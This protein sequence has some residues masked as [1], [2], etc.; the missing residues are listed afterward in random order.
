MAAVYADYANS[1][2]ALANQARKELV[3]TGNLKY[4]KTA[5]DTYRAEVASL[6][7][8]LKAAELNTVRERAA[9]RKANH[10]VDAKIKSGQLDK[11]DVKKASQQALTKYR[12]EVGS[13]SRKKRNIEITDREWEAI[14]AGAVSDN[15]LRRILNNADADAL[16]ERATPRTTNTLSSAQINRMK[17]MS[18]SNYTTAEIAAKFGVSPSTVSKY[19]KGVN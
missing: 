16:R 2:K 19:L 10:E 14:Q 7:T 15:T 18:A 6:G 12:D 3:S 8:K 9:Q 5:R 11:N 17:A 13:V 1:M 4:S